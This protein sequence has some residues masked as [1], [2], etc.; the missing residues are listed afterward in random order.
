MGGWILI[1][2]GPQFI[3]EP[4]Y[5]VWPEFWGA[6]HPIT[7]HRMLSGSQSWPSTYV[8]GGSQQGLRFQRC[9]PGVVLGRPPHSW[10]VV[11][12]GALGVLYVC[13]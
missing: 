5:S 3:T 7:F 10:D 1:L 11:S 13:S 9:P 6:C 2:P 8:L 4:S 12:R